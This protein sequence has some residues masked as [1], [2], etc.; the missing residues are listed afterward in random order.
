MAGTARMYASYLL[1]VET[2]AHYA[3]PNT[4]LSIIH[5]RD[6]CPRSDLYCHGRA[7]PAIIRPFPIATAGIPLSIKYRSLDT[8]RKRFTFRFFV[9]M[10]CDPAQLER[11]ATVLFVPRYIYGDATGMAA[12]TELVVHGEPFAVYIR[13]ASHQKLYICS[14]THGEKVVILERV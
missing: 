2:C 7:L 9:T 11:T 13:D 8:K 6:H 4:Q 1:C 12:D 5:Y 14:K 3:F 10:P